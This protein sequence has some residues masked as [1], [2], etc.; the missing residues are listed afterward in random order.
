MKNRLLW[1]PHKN[2]AEIIPRE[3]ADITPISPLA[4][5][6]FITS[7]PPRECGI[8]TYSQDLINAIRDKFGNSF[9]LKVCAL[10]AHEEKHK[11]PQEVSYILHTAN[12]DSYYE[13][14]NAI[15]ANKNIVAVFVQHEFGLFGGEYGEY[16]L[17]FLAHIKKPIITTFHTVLP[18]PDDSRKKIVQNIVEYSKSVIVMTNHS[19]EILTQGYHVKAEK[20]TMISHGTHLVSATD[21]EQHINTLNLENRL[22]LS[23]FGLL[24]SGKSIETAL[25]ALPAIIAQ[26][27]NVLYLVIGKTHPGVVKHEGEKYRDFLEEK[28]LQ[29][30]L[31]EHVRFVNQY[32]S[33]DSLLAY[34]VRTDIYLFTS[35]DP[36]QAVSGTFSY[37]MACGCPI[38]STPIPHANEFLQ[39]AGRIFEFQN[40]EQLATHTIELLSNP[41]LMKV[42]SLNAL[43]KINST[44]WQN[45]A[46]GH[47]N[48]FMKEIGKQNIALNYRMPDI[49][50]AHVRRMTTEIGMIQFSV[51]SSPDINTG[52]TLDDNARALIAITKH[53]LT[54]GDMENIELINTYLNFILMCQQEDGSFLNY[55]DKEVYFCEK[56]KYENL[57]D[58][59]GR[60]IWALGELIAHKHILSTNC[61]MK[62][63]LAMIKALENIPKM[64]SPR[65]LAFAIKGLYYFNFG[66]NDLRIQQ[67]ITSLADNLVSKYRGVSTT[68]WKWFED[69]LTYANSVISEALL[70][71]A[72]RDG[73]SLF[74]EIAKSSFDFLLSIIFQGNEIKVVSHHGWHHRDSNP[75]PFGEQAIDV[76]YTIMAL[77]LFYHIFKDK[78]YLDKM[79]IAFNW[80]LGK[81]HL[82]QIIYNPCTGGCC[83]GLEED[84]V[85]LNQGA[86]STLSYLLARLTMEKYFSQN[87]PI[88]VQEI[89]QIKPYIT[90]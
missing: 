16:L 21:Y 85:N 18:Q 31:Q 80:F 5:I 47:I 41:Q 84:H 13:I 40:A 69:S 64:N 54:T 71:A 65:A 8:A 81:N 87:N 3:T 55:V 34:L 79:E 70:Y 11:Y 75:H 22:V 12:L 25:D 10:E 59:N 14:A 88:S 32:L 63:E 52:Y 74:K 89:Y 45:S 28:V 49:S 72:L 50:L 26:F 20:I 17:T 61:I 66:R 86:E 39:G 27:P 6:L 60:A 48:L 78:S 82:H 68:D 2:I 44:S 58:S 77:S 30:N 62:A 46:I 90:F 53:Y 36:H 9:S 29:L 43:H 67:I 35:K 23:T 73:S 38:I 4:E 57:E 1:F 56:N 19:A 33:L 51:I 42:M 37:A 15:N 7:Y 76:S 24:S 83:D